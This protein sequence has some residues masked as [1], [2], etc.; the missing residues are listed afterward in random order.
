VLALIDREEGGRDAIER[1]G[2]P[3]LSL[4]NATEILSVRKAQHQSSAR[5]PL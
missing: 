4:A 2:I 5:P 3:V 1:I